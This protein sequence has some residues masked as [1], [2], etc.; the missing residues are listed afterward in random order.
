[1]L[2]IVDLPSGMDLIAGFT[3]SSKPFFAEMLPI[4][5]YGVGIVLA[6]VIAVFLILVIKWA[7]GSVL[8]HISK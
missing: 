5:L 2:S 8:E 7:F 4:A 1:M 6:G 3:T